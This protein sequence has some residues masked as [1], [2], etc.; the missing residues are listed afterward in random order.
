MGADNIYRHDYGNIVEQIVWRTVT[1]HL[2]P[3]MAVV[4]RELASVGDPSKMKA[5]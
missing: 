1:H 2:A 3:L 5:A 4:E